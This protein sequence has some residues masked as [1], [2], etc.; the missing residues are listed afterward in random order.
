VGRPARTESPPD[1]HV[2]VSWRDDITGLTEVKARA[3]FETLKRTIEIR[4]G[5]IL[6]DFHKVEPR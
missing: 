1:W 5:P 2:V 6:K 3:M 4:Q